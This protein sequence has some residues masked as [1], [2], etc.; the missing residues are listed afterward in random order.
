[1]TNWQPAGLGA[2]FGITGFEIDSLVGPSLNCSVALTIFRKPRFALSL[3]NLL[4]AMT[5]PRGSTSENVA[6]DDW[7]ITVTNWTTA[8]TD[9]FFWILLSGDLAGIGFS[10]SR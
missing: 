10:R 4:S 2:I 9:C 5:M 3:S 7:R 8:S 6:Y 1:L